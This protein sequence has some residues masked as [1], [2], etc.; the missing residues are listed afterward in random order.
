MK[1]LVTF[2]TEYDEPNPEEIIGFEFFR[3][4]TDDGKH[5]KV[6]A[7]EDVTFG[8]EEFETLDSLINWVDQQRLKSTQRQIDAGWVPPEDYNP[9]PKSTIADIVTPVWQTL[10]ELST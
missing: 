10:F 8:I 9:P 6:G 4:K 2:I 5:I 1:R 7:T 3:F